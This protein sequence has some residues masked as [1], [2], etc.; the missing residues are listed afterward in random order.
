MKTPSDPMATRWQVLEATGRI[1]ALTGPGLERTCHEA[2][3]E[4]ARVALD[5]RAVS[6]LSSA[7]LRVVLSSLKR[8]TRRNGAFA[9][10]APQEAVREVLD[11]SGFSRIILI[12]DDAAKLV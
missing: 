9:L 2:L 6:Y 7:G 5:M 3:T 1:D 11:L 10:I 4:G 8:A 12:V